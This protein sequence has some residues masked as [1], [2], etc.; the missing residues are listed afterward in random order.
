MPND[1]LFTVITQ[2][3][4]DALSV[5]FKIVKVTVFN[6]CVDIIC[7][8]CSISAEI[9]GNLH[10]PRK[11][12]RHLFPTLS[13]IC[14][15]CNAPYL[16]LV[17]SCEHGHLNVLAADGFGLACHGRPGGLLVVAAHADEEEEQRDG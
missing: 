13:A 2:Q 15:D 9:N 6:F 17:C 12:L 5:H 8:K 11:A 1:S 4:D 10:E 16:R 7:I 3:R 14:C